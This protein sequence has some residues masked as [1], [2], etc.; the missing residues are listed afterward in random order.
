MTV[1]G[2][3]KYVQRMNR[4]AWTRIGT[5]EIDE[6]SKNILESALNFIID[7]WKEIIFGTIA[8]FGLLLIMW[9]LSEFKS[10]LKRFFK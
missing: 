1:V 6:N 9:L 7:N 5:Q 10:V 2:H 3:F 4:G 8:L